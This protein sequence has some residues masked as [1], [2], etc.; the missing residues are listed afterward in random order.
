MGPD[1]NINRLMLAANAKVPYKILAIHQV[2]LA[3]TPSGSVFVIGCGPMIGSH[4]A[5]LFATH[6]FPRVALFSR[7]INNLSRDTSFVTAAAPFTSVK[8]YA[9]DV[10]DHNT[11]KVVLE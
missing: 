8:T 5:R 9:V 2:W 6:G 1:L 3:M 10:T 4:V 11:F 7:S